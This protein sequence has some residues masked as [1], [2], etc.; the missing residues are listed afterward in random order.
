MLTGLGAIVRVFDLVDIRVGVVTR[1]SEPADFSAAP[2]GVE[3]RDVTGTPPEPAAAADVPA[4][5]PGRGRLAR[6]GQRAGRGAGKSASVRP[7]RR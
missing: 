5:P 4:P 2:P 1:E 6:R 3:V 7:R